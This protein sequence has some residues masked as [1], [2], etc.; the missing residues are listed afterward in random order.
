MHNSSVQE[1]SPQ[2]EVF[3]PPLVYRIAM[4]VNMPVWQFWSEE[5]QKWL[6]MDDDWNL[7]HNVMVEKSC[8]T[9]QYDIPD[10][11]KK[12]WWHYLANLEDMTQKNESTNKTRPIRRLIPSGCSIGD[13]CSC[14]G[15]CRELQRLVV[16]L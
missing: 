3:E 2:L 15:S 10:K 7:I 14:T 13:G 16:L 9:F 5:K 12:N 11:Y 4:A 6:C 1:A 8:G